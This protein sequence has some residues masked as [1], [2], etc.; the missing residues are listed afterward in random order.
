MVR[1]ATVGFNYNSF[2][3][4][5][6]RHKFSQTLSLVIVCAPFDSRLS[7][8]SGFNLLAATG[9]PCA[10][11]A[12]TAGSGPR[13][14]QRRRRRRAGRQ[15]TR[16]SPVIALDAVAVGGGGGG[17]GGGGARTRFWTGDTQERRA[18]AG[19][20]IINFG[21]IWARVVAVDGAT[22][23]ARTPRANWNS[24][25]ELSNQ[26]ENDNEIYGP[27]GRERR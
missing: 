18:E 6:I 10:L 5:L 12:P 13:R 2:S 7:I 23:A 19:V 21:F 4:F 1:A 14:R 24:A 26:S 8:A 9:R 22:A 17:A 11:G 27:A 25:R 16:T 15:L 20:N 3:K